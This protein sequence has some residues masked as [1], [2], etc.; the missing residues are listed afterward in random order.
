MAGAAA[1]VRLTV[2]VALA[3]GAAAGVAEPVPQGE[4]MYCDLL[5]TAAG[6][7]TELAGVIDQ[8]S[9]LVL[10]IDEF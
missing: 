4:W 2:P 7:V 10:P 9:H 8:T 5:A 1:G 3:P 6:G